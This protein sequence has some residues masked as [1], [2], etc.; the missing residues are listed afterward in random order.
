MAVVCQISG[1]EG[2]GKSRAVKDLEDMYPGK[3]YYIN[4]DKKSLP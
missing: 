4:A 2:T 1:E 3:T